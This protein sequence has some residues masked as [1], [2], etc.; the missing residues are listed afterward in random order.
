MT[1]LW[2]LKP[3]G[4]DRDPTYFYLR[5]PESPGNTATPSGM[6]LIPRLLYLMSHCGHFSVHPSKASNLCLDK[7]LLSEMPCGQCCEG[8]MHFHPQSCCAVRAMPQQPCCGSSERYGAGPE[9]SLEVRAGDRRLSRQCFSDT[10]EGQ[11]AQPGDSAA[12]TWG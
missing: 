7:Y 9:G 11:R 3:G 4:G 8:E 5:P 6:S 2:L 10:S 1:S 12:G